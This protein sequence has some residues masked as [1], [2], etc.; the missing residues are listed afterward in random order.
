MSLLNLMKWGRCM[1]RWM[2]LLLCVLLAIGACLT[3]SGCSEA[4]PA[5]DHTLGDYEVVIKDHRLA[6]DENGTDV[7]IVTFDFTNHWEE[8]ISFYGALLI[9]AYQGDIGLIECDAPTIEGYSEADMLRN[10]KTG[11]TIE[12]E[13]AFELDDTATDVTVE[14]SELF[15]FDSRKLTKTFSLQ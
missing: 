11:A 9:E 6:K 13:M 1:K 12:V 2:T 5:G 10:I 15:S 7:I 14:V 3:A 4:A 8:S